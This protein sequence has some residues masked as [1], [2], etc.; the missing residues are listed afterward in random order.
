MSS[1]VRTTV[2]AFALAATWNM[3][4][5]AQDSSAAHA[6]PLTAPIPVDP[7]VTSGVLPN[8]LH[9]YIRENH[10]PEHRAELR[11]VVNA[12]SILEDS[13]QRGLAHLIE[14][15]SFGGTTHFKREALVNYLESTGVRF[16][17]DLNAGTSFDETIYQLTVPTDSAKLLQRGI[18]ILGDWAG[19]VTFDTAALRRERR[20]VTEEWRLGRGAGQRIE[21]KQFP[22]LFANSRYARRLPIGDPH[23]IATAPRSELLRFYHD[24]YRP[25]LMAVVL[26]GDFDKTQVE[27]WVK[28]DLGSVREPATKRDR[29]IFPVPDHDSTYVSVVTDPEATTSV[30][31]MYFLQPVRRDSTVG[32]YRQALV[33]ALYND[34]LDDRL[35]EITQRPNAPF[36]GAE[37][38][39]GSLIRSKEVYELAA[40]VKDGGVA[41]GLRAV[42]TEAARVEQHGFTS[43][44][45]A[46]EKENILR[47]TEQAYAERAKTSSGVFVSDYIDNFLDHSAM[48]SLAQEWD[49]T[50]ALLP[51]ITLDE[52][53]ALAS[54]WLSGRSRVITASG[55]S[56]DSTV[57]PN[58]TELAAMA[59]SVEHTPV[60]AY[61]DSVANSPLVPQPPTPG[62]VVSSRTV[63]AVGVT[64]WTLSNG[65]HVLL[66][67]TTFKD[68]ELLFRAFGPGGTSLADDS[69][70]V[71]ARTASDLVDAS[72][73]GAFN[74]TELQKALAG[75]T[76]SADPY[77][78]SYEQ[79]VSGG[80]SPRDAEAMFQLMYLYF[81]APRADTSAYLAYQTRMKELLANR[82][83]SPASAFADTI[84]ATLY[85]HNPRL[86]PP[87]S[88]TYDKM[89]LGES[90]A[91]YRAR[92]ANASDF[93]FIFVGNIDTTTLKP[94][95]ERYI[96]GL[97]SSS[98]RQA[99]RD[100]GIEFARGAIHRDVHRGAE[101]KSNTDIIYTGPFTFTR[102]AVY[103]MQ[104]LEDVLQIRLR[105]RLREQLGGTYG[106]NVSANPSQFP[107]ARYEI[108]ITFGSSPERVTELVRAAHA[109]L[110]S[111]KTY[112]PTASD[113]EKVRETELRE[114]E[115]G[116]TQNGFWL[117]V[118]HSYLYNQWNLDE[119]PAF[120]DEVHALNAEAVRDAARKYLDDQNVVQVSLYP[121]LGASR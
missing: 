15:M 113:L 74:A 34:M 33:R 8:G 36:L 55:P 92:F 23:I 93:T 99:W 41:R 118:L 30:V 56:R 107:R 25:D 114:R 46:R 58:A 120:T 86:A 21:D 66:K 19:G 22:V 68:D 64:E 61:V 24:W 73:V 109:E 29:Q 78:G 72:G 42:L 100:V 16:G 49:L 104:A 43:T 20:V 106:V 75:K 119:I 102:H 35:A 38:N 77:I 115:T 91:F 121:V 108:A 70:L 65:V 101:P 1:V 51:G 47:G 98:T 94:L 11:L 76:V 79:G 112:G 44:E 14:H 59:D 60:V 97:P 28:Q 116:L 83:A 5:R 45:L 50:R 105:E 88:A 82:S 89:D 32:D 81:T 67:P 111:I 7:D 96:G 85:Q 17:A 57:M 53:N 18:Q 10:K 71:P 63:P 27:Q 52:V 2:I 26:V 110:D 13:A 3:G 90:L 103:E 84:Q 4:A 54:K 40:L 62:R 95:I 87:T 37:S 117:T 48:P 80:G 31:T 6:P 39:Q 9:Y 12:G 69:M